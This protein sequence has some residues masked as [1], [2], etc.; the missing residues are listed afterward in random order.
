MAKRI[1]IVGESGSGKST[2]LR[3]LNPKETFI[4]NVEGKEFPFRPK[5]YSKVEELPPVKGNVLTT[6]DA[7]LVVKT[8]QY[9]SDNRPEI[10]NV[11][12]DDWQYVSMHTFIDKI[13]VKGYE[14]FN[15]MGADIKNMACAP[16]TLRDNLNV[17]YLTHPESLRDEI[18]GETKYKAKTLGKLVDNYVTLDGLFSIVLYTDVVK[19]KEGV[20]H[21]F[22]TQN[23]GNTTAKTPIDM[24]ESVRIPND[25]NYVNQKIEEYYKV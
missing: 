25:L 4:I 2:S 23:E 6:H 17:Y 10:K 9:I 1:L 19:T 13:K 12:V 18:T 16:K 11:I 15:L 24:F 5:G 22:I 8:L 7:E 3:N 21:Y 20:E 14:K